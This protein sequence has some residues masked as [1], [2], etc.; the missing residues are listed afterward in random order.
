MK[1][2]YSQMAM[3][4][5]LVFTVITL[6]ASNSFTA[7]KVKATALQNGCYQVGTLTLNLNPACSHPQ[8]VP[9]PT[10]SP[11]TPITPNLKLPP[12][13]RFLEAVASK[14]SPIPTSGSFEYILLRQYG[15]IFLNQEPG[16]KLPPT[17][18]FTGEQ[19]AKD[20]Q[21]SLT[22]AQVNGT[23]NCYLQKP[24]ADALNLA[25]GQTSIPLKSGY[26]GGDCTRT[27]A[28]HLRFWQKYADSQTLQRVRRGQDVAILHLVAPPGSSQ[29]L[30]GLAID[31]RPTNQTQRAI[32][33]QHGWFQ[34]VEKD[35][36]H[37][38][39]VGLSAA[40]L[41]QFGFKNKSDGGISYWVTPL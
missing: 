41:Q 25:R 22:M 14:L 2:I 3:I 1:R 23:D 27:F 35:L 24:A 21:A 7:S 13:E 37:W 34:T 40:Q 18:I 20:F 17:V 6:V 8:N 15:A 9:K 12:P 30:F 32:L 31:L 11:I 33:A 16:I 28:T 39:Y 26:G 29:H 36:P 4:A 38:T 19:Q 10:Q 5:I